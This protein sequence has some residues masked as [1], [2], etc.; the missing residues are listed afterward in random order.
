MELQ[1]A[2]PLVNTGVRICIG[3]GSSRISITG[4]SMRCRECGAGYERADMPKLR[5]RPGD[6]V[7]VVNG[8]DAE[9]PHMEDGEAVYTVKKINQ[10]DGGAMRYLLES[11]SSPIMIDYV[12]G[13]A[14]YLERVGRKWGQAA[15]AAEGAAAGMP[16]VPAWTPG[17][18]P[19][20]VSSAY[21]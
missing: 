13:P 17:P 21:E 7:R 10:D 9:E 12:E 5:F 3:C 16:Y 1:R 18:H 4:E 8:E 14:T 20:A 15:S 11:A 2:A 19:T 6:I